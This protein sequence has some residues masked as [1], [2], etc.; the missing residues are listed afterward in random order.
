[1]LR[2]LSMREVE[3]YGGWMDGRRSR[4]W[5]LTRQSS[6]HDLSFALRRLAV[7][8][9]V[10]IASANDT[11]H[12]WTILL[13]CSTHFFFLLFEIVIDFVH[14]ASGMCWRVTLHMKRPTTYRWTLIISSLLR[15]TSIALLRISSTIAGAKEDMSRSASSSCH[16]VLHSL[17]S[18]PVVRGSCG[19]KRKSQALGTA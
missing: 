16:L 11:S 6:I 19:L 12:Q 10:G 13:F 7:E 3:R 1:M 14:R 18:Y 5:R 8:D 2:C 9:L 4:R 17:H 15:W